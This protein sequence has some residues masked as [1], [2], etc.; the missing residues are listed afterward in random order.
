MRNH[1]VRTANEVTV[2]SSENVDQ[3]LV[4]PD[5]I[6]RSDPMDLVHLA[7]TVMKGDQFVRSTTAGKLLVIVDQ[8][9]A[10]QKKVVIIINIVSPY[11]CWILLPCT[12][13]LLCSLMKFCS[14]PSEM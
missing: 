6:R 10:L 2:R 7:E 5:R 3:Q 12:L 1:H 8:I 9:R 4:N 11:V 14:L 13:L